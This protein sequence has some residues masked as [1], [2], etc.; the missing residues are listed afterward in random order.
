MRLRSM[1]LNATHL[2]ERVPPNVQGNR[3]ADEL[4]TEDQSMCRR[5]RLTVGLGG[6]IV[7]HDNN[8][9]FHVISLD[10]RAIHLTKAVA[11]IKSR[12]IERGFNHNRIAPGA[13][14][15]RKCMLKNA[16]TDSEADHRTL[17]ING[18][19]DA[20]ARFAEANDLA[21]GFGNK[22][23]GPANGLEVPIRRSTEQPTLDYL[24]RVVT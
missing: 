6:S 10:A 18:N 14:R 17:D 19:D 2:S 1:S 22:D 9:Y 7:S 21:I 24:R 13:S 3:P 20:R 12:C 23:G 16:S 5:V 11:S 15:Q 8:R 4:R